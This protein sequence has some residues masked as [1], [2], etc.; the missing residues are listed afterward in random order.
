MWRERKIMSMEISLFL[1]PQVSGLW[2]F[3]GKTSS[4]VFDRY[5]VYLLPFTLESVLSPRYEKYV[6]GIWYLNARHAWALGSHI[7]HV[8]E[9]YHPANG[10]KYVSSNV[11]LESKIQCTMTGN[12]QLAWVPAWYIF[13]VLRQFKI[14][15]IYLTYL[16]NT[17]WRRIFNWLWVPAILNM[18]RF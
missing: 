3:S 6:L 10:G 4:R 8:G 1:I 11:L 15:R 18:M 7:F 9:I 5:S 13:N 12:I 2:L 16:V 14:M 17:Q